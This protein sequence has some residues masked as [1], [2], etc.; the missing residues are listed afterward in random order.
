[1]IASYFGHELNVPDKMINQYTEELKP[2]L[3]DEEELYNLRDAIYSLLCLVDLYP[4][5]LDQE[6]YR[7]DFIQALAMKEALFNLKVLHDA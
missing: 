4:S 7:K 2:V 3:E 6:R 1:M 5:L